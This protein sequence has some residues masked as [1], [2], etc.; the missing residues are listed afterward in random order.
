MHQNQFALAIL[1]KVDAESL[2]KFQ[3]NIKIKLNMARFSRL[4]FRFS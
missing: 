2:P 3:V 1:R 4:T